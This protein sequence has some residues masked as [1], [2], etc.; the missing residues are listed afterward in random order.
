MTKLLLRPISG[1]RHQLRVHCLYLGH[2]IG[3]EGG[4]EGGGEGRREGGRKLCELAL[5]YYRTYLL[6]SPSFLPSFLPPSLPPSSWRQH[7]QRRHDLS[8]YDASRPRAHP[9]LPRRQGTI[10][11]LPSLIPS[12][13]SPLPSLLLSIACPCISSLYSHFHLPSLPPSFLPSLAQGAGAT[14]TIRTEDPFDGK[15]FTPL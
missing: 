15:Y 13:S 7:L 8:S 3:E 5:L 9:P 11:P 10:Y 6:S 12:L 1:R 14:L 2:P 4:S